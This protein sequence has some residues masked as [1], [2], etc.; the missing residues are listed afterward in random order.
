[1]LQWLTVQCLEIRP[2]VST[3]LTSWLMLTNPGGWRQNIPLEFP[4]IY[5]FRQQFCVLVLHLQQRQ[6]PSL[7][8]N[9]PIGQPQNTH[10]PV[11]SETF[12]TLALSSFGVTFAPVV[13]NAL[14]S[15]VWSKP[16]FWTSLRA[17]C[18]LQSNNGKTEGKVNAD[19]SLTNPE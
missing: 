16:S 12:S 15:T 2:D 13:A 8:M 6:K 11:T 10:T 14:L 5:R 1:M 3:L 17:N 7:G 18:P 19:A 4:Q 9:G